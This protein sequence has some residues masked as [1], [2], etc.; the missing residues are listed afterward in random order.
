MTI[1][2]CTAGF[3]G[4]NGLKIFWRFIVPLVLAIL[5]AAGLTLGF[6]ERSS[7]WWPNRPWYLQRGYLYLAAAIFVALFIASLWKTLRWG[8]ESEEYAELLKEEADEEKRR[9]GGT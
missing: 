5:L 2:D 6:M 1:L 4:D 7:V 3:A 8:K 9:G